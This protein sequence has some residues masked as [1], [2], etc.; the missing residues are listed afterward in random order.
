[1]EQ[2]AREWGEAKVGGGWFKVGGGDNP[3]HINIY[4]FFGHTFYIWDQEQLSNYG[5]ELE[6]LQI[7]AKLKQHLSLVK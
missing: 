6:Y 1:M 5:V 3:F 7:D 4:I 2:F